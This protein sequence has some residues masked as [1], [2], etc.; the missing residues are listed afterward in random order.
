MVGLKKMCKAL[1]IKLM[2][3]GRIRRK[4]F[5]LLSVVLALIIIFTATGLVI[6]TFNSAIGMV[7]NFKTTLASAEEKLTEEGTKNIPKLN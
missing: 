1:G 7:N 3:F 6:K 2:G 4:A 5:G